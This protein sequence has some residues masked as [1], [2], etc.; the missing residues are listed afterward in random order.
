MKCGKAKR[1]LP[2]YIGNDLS[3]R[4]QDAVKEHL[5]SCSVCQDEHSRLLSAVG[6]SR[7]WLQ[8]QE[9]KWNETTWKQVVSRAVSQKNDSRKALLPWP[10]MPVTAYALM[11]FFAIALTVLVVRGPSGD[12]GTSV[13]AADFP[14]SSSFTQSEPTSQD[15]VA[16]TLVSRES[17]LKVQWFFNRN[18]NLKEDTE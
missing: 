11:L 16:L 8:Q 3:L 9:L 4:R 15:V 18:I 2:L 1:W 14:G 13:Q 10:F 12:P 6:Q 17:G 5:D 7:R